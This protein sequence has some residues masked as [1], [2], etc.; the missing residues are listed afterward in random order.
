[1]LILYLF[2]REL[3]N[4]LCS[5]LSFSA[6]LSESARQERLRQFSNR[7]AARETRV[8][9]AQAAVST[10]TNVPPDSTL[11]SA[12]RGALQTTPNLPSLFPASTMRGLGHEPS[13]QQAEP[14]VPAFAGEVHVEDH[15][16]V[17]S[18]HRNG[19]HH[20]RVVPAVQRM[21]QRT[22]GRMQ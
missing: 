21:Q 6:N 14:A 1:M 10:F 12:L 19:Q 4:S 16:T 17:F 7:V 3:C 18:H 8:Q 20:R 15:S 5:S 9:T 2:L 11:H 22:G 13:A